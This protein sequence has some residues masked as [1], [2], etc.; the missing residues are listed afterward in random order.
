MSWMTK[1]RASSKPSDM[2]SSGDCRR[3]TEGYAV[4]SSLRSLPEVVV[5]KTGLPRRSSQPIAHWGDISPASQGFA[6]AVFVL[7]RSRE[8]RLVSRAGL[9]PAAGRGSWSLAEGFAVPF[10]SEY[11]GRGTALRPPAGDGGRP[12]PEGGAEGHG[13]SRRRPRFVVVGRGVCSPVLFRVRGGGRP[14]D[15]P[16]ATVGGRGLKAEPK[17]TVDPAAGRGSWSLAEGFAVPFFS[18][19][20][21]RGTALRPPAGDGGRPGPEGGAEGHGQPATTESPQR[22]DDRVE[23]VSRAGFEPATTGLKVRCSTN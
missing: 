12:G 15:H 4:T 21:G 5:E 20:E 2:S 6:V 13:R 10:F 18:E 7:S 22:H 16:L 8:R 23:L 19:Y 17:V 14:Y 11:E 3:V 1:P 9:D